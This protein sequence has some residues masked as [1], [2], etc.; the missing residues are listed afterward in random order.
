M[1]YV[2]VIAIILGAFLLWNADRNDRA[3]N[4]YPDCIAHEARAAEYKGTDEQAWKL[5]APLC[6]E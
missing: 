2:I 6:S 5:F 4:A 1:R 3:L